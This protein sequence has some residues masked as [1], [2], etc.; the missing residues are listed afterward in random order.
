MRMATGRFPG[1]AGLRHQSHGT[2]LKPCESIDGIP[3]VVYIS[4]LCLLKRTLAT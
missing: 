1:Q 3:R 4:S 2:E